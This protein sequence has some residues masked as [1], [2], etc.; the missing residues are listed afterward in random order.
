MLNLR[1]LMP[2]GI[3]RLWEYGDRLRALGLPPS[4]AR[5]RAYRKALDVTQIELLPRDALAHLDCVVD[6]GANSG[7]WSI[8][9]AMLTGARQIIA[10]EPV[11]AVF[12]RLR[13]GA[14]TF[15]HIQCVPQAVGSASGTVEMQVHQL[16]QMSSIL[17][18]REEARAVHGMGED[19][20]MC[21]RVPMTTLDE[22]LVGYDQISLLKVDVQ[23]YERE[24]FAGARAVL[25][26]SATLMVEVTYASYYQGDSQF[27]E[28]HQLITSAAPLKLWG[29]SA[30]HCAASGKPMWA[31]AV[32]VQ[33]R[34]T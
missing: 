24:V 29:V 8:G 3:V 15:P 6:V 18:L 20:P 1:Y 14:R 23:G 31:D 16:D 13:E 10:Y 4:W 27:G 28:M 12:E 21:V 5:R 11:P 2:A 22:D 32:Y 26:R 33:E 9:I 7:E 25:Q 19:V 34:Y 17:P 30:P